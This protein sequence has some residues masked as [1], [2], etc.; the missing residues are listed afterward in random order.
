[1]SATAGHAVTNPQSSGLLY[2]TFLGGS[3]DD[4]GYSIAVDGAGE[5]YVTGFTKSANF[6]ASRGPGYDTS[7]NSGD[8]A[9][10]VKLDA[11]GTSLLY[12]TFLGGSSYDYGLS[13]AVDGA[14]QAYV[15]GFTLSPDFPASLGP[16]YDT[17]LN[18]G[19]AFVVKL[20]A[21]GTGLRYA[22]FLG[23]SD[24]EWGYGIAVD[25]AG[26]AYVMGITGSAD[27]PASLGPGYDTSYN[28]DQ[29]AFVVKLDAAGASLLYATF[30]GGSSLDHSES[31]AVDGAGQA[32]V[33]GRT[34][35]ADFPASLGP[36]YDTSF[37][38]YGDAFVIKLDAAGTALRYAT[39]L[40]GSNDDWGNGIAVDGAGQA[41]VTG[42]THSADFPASLSPGYD[43]SFN[44]DWDAFVV[45]V[46]AT[47]TA[48]R[49]ASFLGGS[50]HDSGWGIAVDRAG[51]AYVTGTTFSADFPA[52]LGPGYDTSFNDWTDAFVVKL[53]RGRR[54]PALR[55]LPRR[56]QRRGWRIPASPWT[57]PARPT[58]RVI[59]CH[60]TFRPASAPATTPPTTT[61]ATH[62][63]SSWTC[64]PG[65]A[66]RRATGR[67]WCHRPVRPS[68]STTAT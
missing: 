41:Y 18:E 57:A 60:R 37:N 45:K 21:A 49:Y 11:A 29:D 52:S 17:S 50:D 61:A 38:G 1:M 54:R 53:Q 59:P 4:G 24:S 64:P 16:G 20:D 22:T 62:S 55:H 66:G 6:P 28:S 42:Q 65:Q 14:G 15:T 32:Y 36:G 13:I 7:Y 68:S 39:F 8:D 44:G 10:V 51:Q 25:G 63:S 23:G 67:S 3:E 43:T 5:T 35:S 30:L 19:D 34:Y 40:G 47:G 48:L 26:Q 12:A 33:T 9:F 27:F 56:Q 46:D 2:A 31:I 58:S